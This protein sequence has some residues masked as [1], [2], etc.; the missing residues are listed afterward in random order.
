MQTSYAESELFDNF[1]ALLEAYDFNAE[2]D[3]F[4]FGRFQLFKKKKARHELRALF[5][6]LWKLALKQSFPKRCEQ[7]FA[8][9]LQQNKLDVDA[10]GHATMLFRSIEVYNT[11]LAEHGTQ[12]FS[13][14]ADFLTSQLVTDLKR[15]QHITLK[16]ALSIRSTY[17]MVFDRLI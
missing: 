16:L 5:I 7:C 13:G 10:A 11:L 12:N 17:N 14:V 2:L 1:N 6:A 15:K 4:E 3:V 9:Y 8:S